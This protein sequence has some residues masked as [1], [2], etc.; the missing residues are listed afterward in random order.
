[1]IKSITTSKLFITSSRQQSI[2]AAIQNPINAELVQQMSEYLSEESAEVLNEAIRENAPEKSADTFNPNGEG[3]SQSIRPSTSEGGDATTTSPSSA[4]VFDDYSMADPESSES[5]SESTPTESDS[6]EET[7][8]VQG[9]VVIASTNVD[10]MAMLDPNVL[11]GTLNAQAET[12][13][14]LRIEII[15][16]ELWIYYNDEVNLNDTMVAVFELLNA[17]GYTCLKFNR[18]G[19]SNNAVIFDIKANHEDIKPISEVSEEE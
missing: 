7:S 2:L 15:D 8:D 18:L 19:R 11:K 3:D 12:A 14:V 4:N 1:M 9:Q 16:D 13:G 5:A 6:V 17:T 10:S